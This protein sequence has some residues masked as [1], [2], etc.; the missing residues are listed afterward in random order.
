M[1]P[2][3]SGNAAIP[4]RPTQPELRPLNIALRARF[5]VSSKKSAIYSQST[6]N[7]P[8][9]RLNNSGRLIFKPFPIFSMLTSDTFLT[10][11]SIPL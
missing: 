1:A 6:P 11:R 9:I 4:A 3:R 7:G 10:P 5:F 2:L 8:Q